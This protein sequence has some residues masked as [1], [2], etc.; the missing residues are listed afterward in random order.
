[1][2]HIARERI[3]S[4]HRMLSTKDSFQ[5]D[6]YWI[7]HSNLAGEFIATREKLLSLPLSDEENQIM[8]K[9]T[10]TLNTSQPLQSTLAQN[11]ITG[12]DSK[13]IAMIEAVSEAQEQSLSYLDILANTQK[14][15]NIVNLNRAHD[16]YQNTVNYLVLITISMFLF[17]SVLTFYIFNRVSHSA[18]SMLFINR[19]LQTSNYDLEEAKK[20]SEVANI[21]KSD[22][23]ANMSHEIRTPMNAILS[24]IGIL[25]SGKVGEL[26]ETG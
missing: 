11:A 3:F 16:A 26:N 8:A 19:E 9:F 1:M 4:L 6:K 25:R 12:N 13:A 23:L 18:R 17:G 15:R 5:R 2:R 24:V 22:F 20:E 21:A 14:E 7:R 10:I